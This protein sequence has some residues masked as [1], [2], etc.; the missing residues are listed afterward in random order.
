MTHKF[1]QYNTSIKIGITF[2][3]PFTL[4]ENSI[5][6]RV[7]NTGKNRLLYLFS[8][9]FSFFFLCDVGFNS[10]ELN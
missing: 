9:C 1:D 10:N 3:S 6:T 7:D 8:L 4:Y 2:M 5:P